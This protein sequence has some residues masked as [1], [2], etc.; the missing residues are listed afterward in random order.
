MIVCLH[1]FK[2]AKANA[3][4]GFKI[5]QDSISRNEFNLFLFVKI[6]CGCKSK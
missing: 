6:L 5:L 4:P 3:K 2:Q 1:N